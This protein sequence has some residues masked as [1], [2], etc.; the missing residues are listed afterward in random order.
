MNR[1]KC[2]ELAEAVG[3]E[4][5]APELEPERLAGAKYAVQIILDEL[6]WHFRNLP[7]REEFWAIAEEACKRAWAKR[8]WLRAEREKQLG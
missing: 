6:R 2:K 4:I 3:L 1:K 8:D 7:S 5:L